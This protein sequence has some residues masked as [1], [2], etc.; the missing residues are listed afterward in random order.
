MSVNAARVTT[1][2]SIHFALK[3]GKKKRRK[4]VYLGVFIFLSSLSQE[5]KKT[6]TIIASIFRMS[7]LLKIY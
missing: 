7:F 2:C 6:W 4:K 3:E 5:N 1:I